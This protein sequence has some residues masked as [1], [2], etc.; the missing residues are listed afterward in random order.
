[1][2]FVAH[3]QAV[4]LRELLK[5][6]PSFCSEELGYAIKNQKLGPETLKLYKPRNKP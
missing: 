3:N 4:E 5:L 2:K 1:L 6:E